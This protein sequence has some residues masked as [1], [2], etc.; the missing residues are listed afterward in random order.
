MLTLFK[1]SQLV[2]GQLV[3]GQLVTNVTVQTS[4]PLVKQNTLKIS[5]ISEVGFSSFKTLLT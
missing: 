5:Y 2:T 3:T 4:Q 1:F